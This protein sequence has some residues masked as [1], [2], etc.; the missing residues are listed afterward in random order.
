MPFI[1]TREAN[2][3]RAAAA[4]A[5]AKVDQ[6]TAT[7]PPISSSPEDGEA[8][9]SSELPPDRPAKR[10]GHAV[11]DENGKW[12]P[13]G[14]GPGWCNPPVGS[15]FKKGGKGGPGR[16]KGSISHDR[17]MRKHLAQKRT[18]RV[19]GK[20][21]KIAAHE[22]VVMTTVKAAAEGKD[23]DARKFVLAESARLF[24]EDKNA[25]DLPVSELNASDA[26]SLA[27]LRREIRED[28]LRELGKNQADEQ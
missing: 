12:L 16:P 28:V 7:P 1:T 13:T 27:E 15:Q 11:K 24:G 23:R 6:H 18:V 4:A 19:D 9:R 22:L 8:S 20:E 2:R 5:A 26:L 3:R 17:L 10:R 21:T 25:F 14:S